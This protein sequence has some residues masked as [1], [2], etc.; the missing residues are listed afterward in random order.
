MIEEREEILSKKENQALI[1]NNLEENISELKSQIDS[2]EQKLNALDRI[3]QEMQ[4]SVVEN[5]SFNN[6]NKE[7]TT[8]VNQINREQMQII[9]S[10]INDI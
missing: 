10:G 2:L 9:T 1:N 5:E 6:L 3:N 4:I 7:E 8:F